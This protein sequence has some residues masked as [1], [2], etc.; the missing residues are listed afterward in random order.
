[1]ELVDDINVCI[2]EQYADKEALEELKR[3][4]ALSLLRLLNGYIAYLQKQK[5][6]K[7]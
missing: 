4:D 6:T 7:V 5:A 2:D 3:E 1:M